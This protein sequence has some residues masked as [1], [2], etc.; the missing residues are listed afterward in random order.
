MAFRWEA[1]NCQ[2]VWKI[3]RRGFVRRRRGRYVER[4]A[5]VTEAGVVWCAAGAV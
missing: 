5:E 2:I 3:S 1:K 4:A